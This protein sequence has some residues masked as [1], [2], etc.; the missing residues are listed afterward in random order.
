MKAW[1]TFS[2]NKGDV[3]CFCDWNVEL[4]STTVTLL[5]TSNLTSFALKQKLCLLLAIGA[6]SP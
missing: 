3:I 4:R 6:G 2:T 1:T 5:E